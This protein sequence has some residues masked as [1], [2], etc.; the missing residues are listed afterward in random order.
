[1][2]SPLRANHFPGPASA[3]LEGV[4][5]AALALDT[6]RSASANVREA[7]SVLVGAGWIDAGA[8]WCRAEGSDTLRRVDATDAEDAEDAAPGSLP[9]SLPAAAIPGA[10]SPVLLPEDLQTGAASSSPGDGSV[11]PELSPDAGF[12]LVVPLGDEGVWWMW[13]G[14]SSTVFSA[15]EREAAQR[16][17]DKLRRCLLGSHPLPFGPSTQTLPTD[18]LATGSAS[19]DSEET[20][21]ASPSALRAMESR[22]KTLVDRMQAAVVVLDDERRVTYANDAAWSLFDVDPEDLGYRDDGMPTERGMSLT[23]SIQHVRDQLAD[24]ETFA[25]KIQTR[26]DDQIPVRRERVDFVDGTVVERSYAPIRAAGETMGHMFVYWDVTDRHDTQEALRESEERWR[27]LVEEHPGPI[28]VTVDGTFEY[29]NQAAVELFGAESAEDLEGRDVIDFAHPD[30]R[31]EIRTR[32]AQITDDRSSTEPFE[33]RTVRLDGEERIV[34]VRSVPVTYRG[35]PAAQ[36]MVRD[37][38]KQREAEKELQEAKER[39]EE[40][41]QAKEQF[42]SMMTHDLR[43]PLH[44]VI[45]LSDLLAETNLTPQ[46]QEYLDDIRFSADSLLEL[47]N[48]LLDV[49]K[50]NAG[51]LQLDVQPFSPFRLA[52]QVVDT[53]QE[54]AASKGLDLR[55]DVDPGLPDP[56]AGDPLRIKQIL[57]NLLSNALTATEDGSVEIQLAPAS[58]LGDAPQPGDPPARDADETHWI[59]LR[60]ADTGPGIPPEDRERIFESFTRL[61]RSSADADAPESGGSRASTAGTGLGLSIVRDLVD[62]HGGEI[63]L[64]S[65]VGEGS[66]FTV[67]LP[68]A[69]PDAQAEP[70]SQT[71]PPVRS[72]DAGASGSSSLR[73]LST[74]RPEAS[75]PP[76]SAGH[77]DSGDDP[78][79]SGVRVLLVEDTPSNRD[80]A[81][82][83]LTSA[84]AEVVSVPRGEEALD[85]IREASFDCVLMD[86]QLPDIDGFETARRIR[87]EHTREEL[88]ILA[89]SAS[90]LEERRR[91]IHDAGMD[92]SLTKPFRVLQL[93]REVSRLISRSRRSSPPEPDASPASPSLPD[94][95]GSSLPDDAPP[96]HTRPVIDPAALERNAQAYELSPGDVIDMFMKDADAFEQALSSTSNDPNAIRAACHDLKT[97]A[98]LAGAF[99]LF[100]LLTDVESRRRPVDARTVT[101]LRNHVQAAR[102]ALE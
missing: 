99:R 10:G 46:Q 36:T 6:S 72:R 52:N 65:T 31:D 23:D 82:H 19:P 25:E 38:T 63:A 81:E 40:V 16:L 42:L 28:Y 96:H 24:P 45:G 97:S 54:E 5:D 80:F 102:R 67:C 48:D 101:T 11:P 94:D 90:N 3:R 47:I 69:E 1:M 84:G 12:A 49:S 60:V 98:Y 44:A 57:W 35:Q 70:G 87:E 34:V 93:R 22:F 18:D 88:P 15:R 20:G 4:L 78:D 64:D 56:L 51:R 73:P 71:A 17:G 14:P 29:V 75:P 100:D 91:D 58:R 59:A 83:I 26:I 61:P 76:R 27:R 62:L 95:A 30:V 43:T 37:V 7:L 39:A 66:T 13:R 68:L 85:R 2:P 32:K 9:F 86:L 53:M 92:G 79:L 33:H 74:A 77:T 21:D 55:L 89:M 50:M 8:V 41:L